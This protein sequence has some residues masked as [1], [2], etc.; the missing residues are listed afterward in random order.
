MYVK[1]VKIFLQWNILLISE[2]SIL[3]KVWAFKHGNIRMPGGCLCVPDT[4]WFPI[5]TCAEMRID[6]EIYKDAWLWK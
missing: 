5:K 3:V 2:Y 1:R 6:Y 4:N